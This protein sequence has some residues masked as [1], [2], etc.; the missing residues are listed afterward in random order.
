MVNTL[1]FPLLSE[2][3]YNAEM[4]QVLLRLEQLRQSSGIC[5]RVENNTLSV[6]VRRCSWVGYTGRKGIFTPSDLFD[7]PSPTVQERLMLRYMRHYRTTSDIVILFHN[8]R[9]I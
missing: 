4:D 8:W 3:N 7:N 2:E 5:A 9:N 6:L 1:P